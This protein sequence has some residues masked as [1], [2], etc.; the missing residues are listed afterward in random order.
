MIEMH[1]VSAK[2]IVALCLPLCLAQDATK[3]RFEVA[4]VKVSTNSTSASR[5]RPIAGGVEGQNVVLKL[6]LNY[7]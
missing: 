6:L 2:A 1:R 4:S 3:P 7:A 5:F